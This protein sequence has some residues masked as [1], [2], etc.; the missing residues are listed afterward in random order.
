MFQVKNHHSFIPFKAFRETKRE[1]QCGFSFLVP[2]VSESKSRVWYVCVCVCV[3]GVKPIKSV[4]AS[5]CQTSLIWKSD[6]TAYWQW[7]RGTQLAK[8]NY[9]LTRQPPTCVQMRTGVQGH[10]VSSHLIRMRA[11]WTSSLL[12]RLCVCASFFFMWNHGI[13]SL[14]S[15]NSTAP[16]KPSNQSFAQLL[17]SMESMEAA[18]GGKGVGGHHGT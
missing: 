2:S 5:F 11:I 4:A 13:I 1:T 18:T 16:Q 6:I 12:R 9:G 14:D 7:W 17:G 15:N 3:Y 10:A 8:S